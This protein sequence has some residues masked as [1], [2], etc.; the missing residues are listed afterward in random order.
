MCTTIFLI[1][2]TTTAAIGAAPSGAVPGIILDTDFRSDVDDAGTLA[3]LNALVDNGE[4]TL[5]GVMASQTGP[6]VVGAINAVNTWY[7]RGDVPVGLSP[8]DDQRFDD[9]YA[10][11]IGNPENY[12]STQS[13]ATAPDSTTLYRRLLHTAADQSVIIVV[14]GG[15]TCIHRLLL[16]PADPEGDGSIGRTGRELIEAKVRKLVIMGGNFV[17][18][19][20]R[21]HNIALDVEAA[22]TVAESWPTPIVYSGFEIGQPVMTGGAM[23]HPEMNPVA[24]AYELFPA[25]GVGTIASSSSYDQTALYY[26]VRGT[27]ADERVLWRL[28]DPGWAS[29][30]EARTRF[31]RNAWGRHRHLIRHASNDEV[32][33]VIEGLMIQPPRHHGRPVSPARTNPS[34]EHLITDYGALPNDDAHD[35]T[36]IQAALDAA[37]RTGGTV[38]I[39]RGRFISGTIH[40]RNDVRLLFDE[41]A[42]LEGSADW[43]DYGSGRWH[44]ALIV[45][46]NLRNVRIEGPGV[47][48]GVACHNPKGEEGFRGPH[49][50]R[51]NGCRDIA[52][53]DLTITR[54]GNYAVLCL[55]CTGAELSNL[56]IRGGHDGLHAQ[57]CKGFTIRDCDIRTGDD[58]FAGCDN[59]NFEI[60][61]CKINSSCN[62]FR[63]GCVNLVVG[64]CVFWGPGEYAHL[65]SARRGAPRTNMLSAF[66]HF[67]PADRRPRLPSDNWRIEDCRIDN[68]DTVYGYDFERGGWQTGQPAGRIHLRN[69][70]A[71]RVARPLRVLGD[72]DR[73]FELTLENVSIALLED[74]ADQEVLNVTRF[75]RL[76]LRN[77]TLTNSGS[78]PVLIASQGNRVHLTELTIPPT[79]E[80]P[81]R[82]TE[83]DDIRIDGGPGASNKANRPELRYRSSWL[84]NTFNGTP[85]WIPHDID[86]IFVAANG[87]VY[88][89]VRWEENR[90]NVIA[91]KDGRYIAGISPFDFT[92][93]GNV[94]RSV[95]KAIAGNDRTIF[96]SSAYA[97][98]SPAEEAITRRDRPDINAGHRSVNVGVRVAGLAATDEHLF[99]ACADGRIRVFDLDLQPKREF[100]VTSS[101]GKMCIDAEGAL[102]YLDGATIHRY[103]TDGTR[104]GQEIVLPS[105]VVVTALA[106][107]PD[108]RLLVADAGRREQIRM[109]RNIA[110]SPVLD[111]VFGETG[112]IYAGQ[113]PGRHGPMRFLG[114]IGVGADRK[115]NIYVAHSLP[116]EDYLGSAMIQSYTQDGRL[117]WQVMAQ[118]WIDCAAVDPLTGTNVYTK[119]SRYALDFSK[120][121]GQEWTLK[122]TTVHRHL[123]PDDPRLKRPHKGGVLVRILD[124]RRFLYVNDM[125]GKYFVFRFD[126]DNHGE[127]AIPCG[128]V[129]AS[130][131]WYDA[132]GDGR[133]TP[134][135]RIETKTGESRGWWV[136]LD[137]AI[138]QAT[139][140]GGIYKYPLEQVDEHG[141]PVY[142][143]QSRRHFAN[144]GP[145]ADVRRILYDAKA[146][147]LYLGGGTSEHPA[148]HWKPMGPN[149]I[150][151][152]RWREEPVQRWHLTLP[153]QLADFRHESYEPHGFDIAGDCL[154]VVWV[155]AV[156][157][158]DIRRGTVGVYRLDNPTGADGFLGYLESPPE[159]GVQHVGIMDIC[160]AI[161]AYWR[162]N[163]EYIVFI[164]DDGRSKNVMFRW[165]PANER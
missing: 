81:Y 88:T 91:V 101:P 135:E 140:H 155:G 111:R 5:L 30:P 18:A 131:I 41:G 141:V 69:I 48:D 138:W 60:V 63:L 95:G 8:V 24:K 156:P 114:P 97:E 122:A 76:D 22:Q 62:G 110:E 109:Y 112:G 147:A 159:F 31:V 87:T 40:L 38:R 72:A 160:H 115:G 19:N 59:E 118:E 50:I 102:W 149:L 14:I 46:E 42:I 53:R 9:Y 157:E 143:V 98:G 73:R 123:F 4:C 68:V 150:R 43:R 29:F 128:R 148:Q 49:A 120:P 158:H 129:T 92:G 66:V 116:A 96:Y 35:T 137:G 106:V 2:L 85:G 161:N 74:R 121:P 163:G 145:I 124:G 36:G 151:Y 89:N 133:E 82:F 52:I 83:I 16:S 65:I 25:G 162:P 26:A 51:L 144:P 78:K 20:H 56:T 125:H 100:A 23:T 58:C 165:H 57:A 93:G 32:A 54:A 1:V 132:D 86:D 28:S 107:M 130:D 75:G 34:R 136:D 12:P 27:R 70:Q 154:F 21:E 45:G 33:A 79:N 37:A 104:L 10:P 127:I 153:Y 108:G 105:D 15:Q 61:N 152:D 77:V 67:A 164:E 103:R 119:K 13:N 47:I 39:P 71:D 134:D 64:D 80:A 17:D 90:N 113:H 84:G 99:A 11:V 44:D 7:G 146:D 139:R 94:P 3:L 126:P 6:Y 142:S 55:N 117:N